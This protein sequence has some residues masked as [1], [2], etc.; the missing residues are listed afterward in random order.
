MA[1]RLLKRCSAKSIGRVK[2][3]G[4]FLRK[5]SSL[6]FGEFY[7]RAGCIVNVVFFSETKRAK[8]NKNPQIDTNN[9]YMHGH[10]HYGLVSNVLCRGST[11]GAV[12]RAPLACAN[13]S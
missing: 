9:E 2:R 10:A 12:N 4:A 11:L 3:N 7:G 13:S 5:R 6:N 8:S 1:L